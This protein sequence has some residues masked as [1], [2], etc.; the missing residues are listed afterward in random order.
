M[1]LLKKLFR[2]IHSIIAWPLFCFIFFSHM[3][4]SSVVYLIL[5]KSRA[6]VIV[7]Y[8]S[9][10]CLRAIL[11]IGFV[12]PVIKGLDRIPKHGPFVLMA[13]H[14]SLVD[15]PIILM[16]LPRYG[17]FIAKKELKRMP[18]LG[19]SMIFQGHFFIDRSNPKASIRLMDKIGDEVIHREVI[20][21]VFPEGTRSKDGNLAPLKLG[22]FKIATQ[23]G[24][25]ILPCCITGAADILPKKK[26]MFCPG[27]LTIE[28]GAPIPVEK[29]ESKSKADHKAAAEELAVKV[30]QALVDMGCPT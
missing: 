25:P 24:I 30:K 8:L 23:K 14:S 7:H 4:A 3:V 2:L 13:N 28:Y 18:F 26:L 6:H 5:P 29:C 9:S 1:S 15:I 20:L 16:S 12:K 22:S 11:M 27:T 17:C 21:L 19:L 10:I